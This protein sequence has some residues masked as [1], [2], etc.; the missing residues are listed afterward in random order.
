V[1]RAR[2][3]CERR[4]SAETTALVT[5]ATITALPLLLKSSLMKSIG[6]PLGAALAAFFV[7]SKSGPKPPE[8]AK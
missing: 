6:L 2:K 4:R 8:S 1:P 3:K 7:L 5:T